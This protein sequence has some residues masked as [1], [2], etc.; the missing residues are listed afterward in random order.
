MQSAQAIEDSYTQREYRGKRWRRALERG[1]EYQRV[2][3]EKRARLRGRY[4]ATA[5]EQRTYVL[6]RIVIMKFFDCAMNFS[7]DVFRKKIR[8]LCS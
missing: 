5:T 6:S 4:H 3:A 2:L 1:Q 8:R 7:S